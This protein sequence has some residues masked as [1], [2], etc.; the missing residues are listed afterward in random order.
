MGKL[1]SVSEAWRA[2]VGLQEILG[3]EERLSYLAA[4][5]ANLRLNH[6]S[7]RFLHQLYDSAVYSKV[8]SID[9]PTTRPCL[10]LWM[11]VMIDVHPVL[12]GPVLPV[13]R[14][15]PSSVRQP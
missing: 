9:A 7:N 14:V 5:T 3:R 12:L 8:G 4:C 6:Q 13:G 2:V 10:S 15:G 1:L 11:T